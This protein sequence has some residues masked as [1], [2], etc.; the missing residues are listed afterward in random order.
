MRFVAVVLAVNLAIAF[1]IVVHDAESEGNHFG[2]VGDVALQIARAPWT[3]KEILFSKD[4]MEALRNVDFGGQKGW[5]IHDSA[6]GD[7]LEGYVLLS[8]YDG[9]SRRH[10][11]DLVSLPD[12]KLR[13]E[14]RPDASEL[15]KGVPH[16]SSLASY[17]HWD[18][19][20][21][22]VIHPLLLDNGDLLI[23]DHQSVLMRIS[24]CGDM[25]WRRPT[26]LVHHSSEQDHTGAVWVPSYSE[27]A[28]LPKLSANFHDDTLSLVS[29]DGEE[30]FRKSLVEAFVENGLF[31]LMFT[32]GGYSDDPLHLN[33]IQPVLEDGPFWKR[34]DLFLS[35]RH[36]SMLVLYRPSTNKILWSKAGP[37]LAQHDVDILDDH[38]IAVFSNNSY[39]FGNGG[40]VKG[41][42]Q[43][44]VYDFATQTVSALHDDAMAAEKVATQSEG[45][46]DYTES[47]HVIVEQE[48]DGRLLILAP[49]G[50]LFASYV[51]A[52][53]DGRIYRMGWSRYVPV[54][55]GDA[56]LSRM[57]IGSCSG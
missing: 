34:G 26:P 41:H 20:T 2:V 6:A 18:T 30:L 17:Q 43:L 31:H 8:F 40:Y 14:W 51:N 52:A 25:V 57:D 27:P 53:E 42:A 5:Q 22:R 49:D 54:Q 46:A 38:R 33:D 21:Y 15:L 35:L 3:L 4:P 19:T 47:G 56:A 11:V 48:N 37:W 29:V 23:K 45:L 16:T 1:G 13:H 9:D 50:R 55:Q 39:D 28:S 12:L 24:P 32:A 44:L 36:Q 7:G 10:V